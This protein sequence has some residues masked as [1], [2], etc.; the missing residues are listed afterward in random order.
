MELTTGTA[1]PK[2]LRALCGIGIPKCCTFLSSELPKLSCFPSPSLLWK[3]AEPV[4]TDP[5]CRYLIQSHILHSSQAPACLI[6]SEGKLQRQAGSQPIYH[7][8]LSNAFIFAKCCANTNYCRE[9]I[10]PGTALP[11]PCCSQLRN[12]LQLHP[13]QHLAGTSLPPPVTPQHPHTALGSGCS[14]SFSIISKIH[15]QKAPRLVTLQHPGACAARE[16]CRTGCKAARE[17]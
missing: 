8:H 15:I 2:A 7:L 14:Q 6:S 9:L 4:Q 3:G 17:T 13:C 11:G 12:Q 1:V 10:N 16:P 5:T